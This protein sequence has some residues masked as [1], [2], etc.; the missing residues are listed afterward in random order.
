MP[1]YDLCGGYIACKRCASAAIRLS[2]RADKSL[3]DAD[4]APG[5]TSSARRELPC[6]SINSRRTG[7]L[8][9]NATAAP[10]GGKSYDVSSSP[11]EALVLAVDVSN[12]KG[13]L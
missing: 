2:L 11:V 12:V 4:I 10:R 6:A 9:N 3:I 1:R 7:V 8:T 13:D 5:G